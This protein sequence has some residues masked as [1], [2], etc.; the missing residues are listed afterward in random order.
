MNGNAKFAN[1]LTLLIF[2]I[3]EVLNVRVAEEK[4]TQ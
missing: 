4:I 1:L 2:K 3:K